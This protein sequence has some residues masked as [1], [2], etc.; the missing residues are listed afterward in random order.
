MTNPTL[1]PTKKAMRFTMT[2]ERIQKMF[3]EESDDEEFLSFE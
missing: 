1:T 2:H 3:N